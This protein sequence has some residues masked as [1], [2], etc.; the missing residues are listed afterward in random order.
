MKQLDNNQPLGEENKNNKEFSS[1]ASLLKEEG[2]GLDFPK[3]GEIK[4]GTIASISP[5]QIMVSIGA[6]SEG[7]IGGEEFDL[8]PPEVFAQ[9]EIGQDIP[10]YIITPEDSHGNVI[11][12]YVRALEAETWEEASDAMKENET[13]DGKVVGYNRGGLIVS[14]EELR[15]FL[16]ASLLAYSRRSEVSGNTPEERFGQFI[17]EEVT[18]QIIEVDQERR[19]LIFS[20]KAALNETRDTVRDQVIENLN[21][22][23]V[24]E[25]RVTSLADFG[26]FV[27]INGADGLVHISE[28]SWERIRHP[29]EVLKVGQEVEVKVISIDEEKR[30]IGLSIRRLQEDPWQESINNLRVGQLVEANITRLQKFG[31][32][33]MLENGIEGLIHISEIADEHISHPKEVLHEGDDVTLRI[34]KIEPESHR[35]G[36]SLRRVESLAYADMD[37]KEL[38]KELEDSDIKLTSRDTEKILEEEASEVEVEEAAKASVEEAETVEEAKEEEPAKASAEEVET[39]EGTKEEETTKATDESEVE[40]SS[41]EEG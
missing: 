18:F 24:R 9:I 40:E 22:G 41:E 37:M 8:I 25:G 32:F 2:L 3:A 34:I 12:S 1:M 30:H 31:A 4:T 15:G 11:L 5:G 28:I 23:N 27:N 16:P 29:S 20:E 7:I 17:G 14:Y 10:V 13:A 19:R 6:K 39:V 38:E 36:L 26:A 35:I 33:A 21:I